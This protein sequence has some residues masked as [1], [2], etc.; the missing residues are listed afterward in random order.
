MDLNWRY[1]G[2][3]WRHPS[4]PG[5]LALSGLGLLILGPVEILILDKWLGLP[6]ATAWGVGGMLAGLIAIV[7]A[8][9]LDRLRGRTT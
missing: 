9:V 2:Y 7:T 8:F 4:Y 3:N 6:G 5:R 1:Q